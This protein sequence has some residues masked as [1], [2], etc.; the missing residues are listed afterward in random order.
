MWRILLIFALGLNEKSMT[1]SLKTNVAL[2]ALSLLLLFFAVARVFM[3]YKLGYE[4]G[5]DNGRN[6]V[7]SVEGV[8]VEK[9]TLS[10]FQVLQL[11]IIFAESEGN[12]HAVGK[13]NDLGCMQITPVYVKE[14]RRITNDTTYTHSDALNPEKSLEMFRI[15]QDYHNPTHD[16]GTAIRL[17]NKAPWYSNKV[18]RNINRIKAYEE[19]RNLVKDKEHEN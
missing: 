8:V 19:Y 3:G 7:V 12:P 10:D 4:H 13:D 2:C 16:I 9:D 6:A 1:N 17:H 5:Y 14:V 11:A 18:L 15:M